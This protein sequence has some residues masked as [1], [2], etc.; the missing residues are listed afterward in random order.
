[1]APQNFPAEQC[2][3]RNGIRIALFAVIN[4]TIIVPPVISGGP[5][6]CHGGPPAPR[7]A[8]N[9]PDTGRITV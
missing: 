9:H 6:P 4:K 7:P 3:S 1:M 5:F 2:G 8:D